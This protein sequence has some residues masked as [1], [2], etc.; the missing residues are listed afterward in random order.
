MAKTEDKT[1]LVVDDEPNVRL[2]LQT[3]LEDAGF[4]VITASDG[5][6][7]LKMINR[8]APDFISLDLVMPR[9][10]GHKLLYEL[11]KDKNL[12]QIP[13]L[14]VTAHA[15]DEMGR[16]DLDDL[17]ENRVM[18]GPGTYLE[19][20]VSPNAYVHA[21]QRAL[22][23]D[24]SPDMAEKRS[25]KDEL[26]RSLQEASPEAMQRALEALRQNPED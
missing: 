15:D 23:I 17:M 19:K 25:L 4:K 6:E 16:E 3:I 5:E 7:A 11:R 2:Y 12:S 20:P 13:V 18:S 9:K 26:T 8:N 21:I 10:S 14:I 1:I 24:E 22:G